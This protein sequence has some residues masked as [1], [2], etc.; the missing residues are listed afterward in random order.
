MLNMTVVQF[1]P[2]QVWGVV[3]SAQGAAAKFRRRASLDASADAP[4]LKV[5]TE[6]AE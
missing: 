1:A 3:G 6:A 5:G 2:A 4:G